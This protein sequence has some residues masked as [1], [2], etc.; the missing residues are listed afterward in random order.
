MSDDSENDKNLE[1]IKRRR[2]VFNKSENNIIQQH[3]RVKTARKRTAQ[4]ARWLERQLNDPY[5]KKAKSMGLRS[6][7]A[8]KI[9]E[10]DEQ[11]KFF[12]KDS[13]VID[14]GFAPGGWIQIA[15]QKGAKKIVGIDLLEVPHIEGATLIVGDFLEKDM[16]EKLLEILGQKPN[17]IMSDMAANT[18]GHRPTDHIKTI[19]LAEAA[20]EFAIDFLDKGGVFIAK[21]FQGGSETQMLTR[22]KQAFKTVKHF[23]P[24]SSRAESV[25]LYLVALDKK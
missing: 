20:A 1:P 21:V 7:A 8:F 2:Q 14:L 9:L 25:E 23:K 16:P 15:Q 22:L 17:I 18:S 3:E 24:K 6:R 12:N 10:L 19:A 4:S 5:V 13:I 11:F